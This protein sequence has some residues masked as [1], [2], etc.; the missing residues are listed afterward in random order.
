MKFVKSKEKKNR[1]IFQKK[2]NPRLTKP[3]VQMSNLLGD[4]FATGDP[5]IEF[6][7]LRAP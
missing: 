2:S 4:L 3:R 7:M 6:P 5:E 1:L